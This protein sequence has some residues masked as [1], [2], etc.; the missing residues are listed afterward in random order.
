MIAFDVAGGGSN[1]ST[2]VVGSLTDGIGILYM[3][4]GG[5]T[6]AEV[7]SWGGLPMT[8][9]DSGGRWNSGAFSGLNWYVLNP[10]PGSTS[11]S[12]TGGT[13]G[14]GIRMATYSGV[15]QFD[16]IANF[17]HVNNSPVPISN[18]I[19]TMTDGAWIVTMGSDLNGGVAQN[20][21]NMTV[22]SSFGDTIGDTN[23]PISP[24][25]LTTTQFTVLGGASSDVMMQVVLNP[26][27]TGSPNGGA[28]LLKMI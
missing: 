20:G 7:P 12:Y 8:L 3:G 13:P 15:D 10:P 5:A 23:G 28:F 24:A 11:I 21:T 16:P 25:G 2:I 17:A 22:R 26:T 14:N 9:I 19:D 18:A 4:A 6:L 1:P 27:G